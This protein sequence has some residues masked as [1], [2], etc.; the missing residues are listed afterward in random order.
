MGLRSGLRYDTMSTNIVVAGGACDTPARIHS[1]RNVPMTT[2]PPHAHND[3]PIPTSSGIYKITCTANKRFYIGSTVNLSARKRQHF[4][5]LRLSKHCNRHLQRAWDKYGEHA[6]TYEVVE[7][8]LPMS[9][10]AREQY[11]LNKFKPF[12]RRG[13]NIAREAA[14]N[15]GVK[16]SPEVVEKQRNRKHSPETIEKLRLSH[17]GYK[18]TPEALEHI[19]QAN[20][21]RTPEAR[22]KQRQALLGKKQ[23]PE[24]CEKTRQAMIGHKVSPEAREKMRQAK[25]GQVP[26]NKGKKLR[27]KGE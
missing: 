19:R 16:H 18:H 12:G 2:L 9:L 11:W 21:Q 8:V 24:R 1:W 7:L 17:L 15:L 6:F 25:L 4:S 13:F 20:R 5:D 27:K 26:W 23:T 10:P 3:N 22:E 14:S